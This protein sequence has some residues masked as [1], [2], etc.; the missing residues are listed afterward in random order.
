MYTAPENLYR[1]RNGTLGDGRDENGVLRD[2]D[3]RGELLLVAGAS[4]SDDVARDYGLIKVDP[5]L[6]AKTPATEKKP[7]GRANQEVVEVRAS[8]ASNDV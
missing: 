3:E 4:I 6:K 5:S 8:A 7:T 1:M 2:E